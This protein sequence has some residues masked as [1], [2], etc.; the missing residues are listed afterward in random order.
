MNKTEFDDYLETGWECGAN[1]F[2][3]GKIYFSQCCFDDVKKQFELITFCFKAEKY[4]DHSFSPYINK[5]GKY[6]EYQSLI[7][8]TFGSKDEAKTFFLSQ[9]IFEDKSFWEIGDR[10]EWLEDDG[11]LINAD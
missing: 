1:I 7:E 5:N 4:G 11:P 9:K 8:K 2:Y 3:N 10:F 6:I